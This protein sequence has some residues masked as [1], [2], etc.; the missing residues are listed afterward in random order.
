VQTF[1]RSRFHPVATKEDYYRRLLTFRLER[2]VPRMARAQ[3]LG[4]TPIGRAAVVAGWRLDD[5]AVLTIAANLGGEACSATT[6][7]QGPPAF[8]TDADAIVAGKLGAS[9]TVAYI[10]ESA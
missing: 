2:I 7:P 1:E 4:A 6:L 8:A 9:A 3:A 5:G 10:D